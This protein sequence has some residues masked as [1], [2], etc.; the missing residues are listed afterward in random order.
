MMAVWFSAGRAEPGPNSPTVLVLPMA[1]VPF[2][3]AQ[4]GEF[5]SRTVGRRRR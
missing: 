4:F 3:S 1:S 5:R 2:G